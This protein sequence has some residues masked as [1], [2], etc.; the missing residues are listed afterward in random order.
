[1]F[2]VLKNGEKIAF[3]GFYANMSDSAK[4]REYRSI[5]FTRAKTSNARIF[6]IGKNRI[7]IEDKSGKT[8]LYEIIA[9]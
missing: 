8:D 6:A 1:M 4:G 9:G 5:L 7:A 2:Q 3:T